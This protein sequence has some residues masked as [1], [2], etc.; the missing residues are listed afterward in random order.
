MVVYESVHHI[1]RKFFWFLQSV[2]CWG[3]ILLYE[4]LL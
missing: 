3:M 4:Q 1:A 2:S